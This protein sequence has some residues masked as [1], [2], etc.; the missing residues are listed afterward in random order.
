MCEVNVCDSE[1]CEVNVGR[2]GEG[3]GCVC[4]DGEGMCLCL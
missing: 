3:D 1:C 2:N 4:W